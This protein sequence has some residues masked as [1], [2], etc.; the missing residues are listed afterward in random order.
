MLHDESQPI[1]YS[2]SKAPPYEPMGLVRCLKF[3]ATVGHCRARARLLVF[4]MA[5]VGFTCFHMAPPL[6]EWVLKGSHKDC[7]IIG[8][9][10]HRSLAWL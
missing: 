10:K 2:S 3:N 5:H 4:H 1:K 6:C 7:L 8:H 9:C